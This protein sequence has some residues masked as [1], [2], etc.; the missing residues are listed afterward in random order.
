MTP[1]LRE[2]PPWIME[3]MIESQTGLVGAPMPGAEAIGAAVSSAASDGAPI[4]VTGCGTSEHG[5]MAVAE[6][7]SEALRTAGSPARAE[8]RQAL[9]AALDARAGGVCIGVSHEGT[10]RATLLALEAARGA[11][12]TTASIGAHAGSPLA[13]GADC[14]LTTPLVDGSWCHTV[15]YT[16]AILA[17]SAI[18]RAITGE[19]GSGESAIAD[20]LELRP[21]LDAL[22]GRVHAAG[23]IL[24]VGLGADLITARELALKIEEGARIPATALHLES[25]LHGHLA[26][27][28]AGATA[29]VLLAADSRPGERRDWRLR[30]AAGAAEAIGIRAIAIGTAGA[31]SG[32]PEA[33]ATLALPPAAQGAELP[34]ALLAGAVSLQLLTLSLAQLAGVSPDLIR[35]EQ[36]P[37]R[38]AAAVAGN[39]TDW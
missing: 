18:A 30:C 14:A 38:E 19:A 34:H 25:L 21:R 13:A 37:Y 15:A 7:I 23:R 33:V 32:L 31:L 24:A 36:D 28:D 16:S 8:A 22:A 39:R 11:G 4:V 5:A 20:T 3:E 9:D 12:A 6:L 17:G 1:E 2:G 27:C 26:G 29:L 35:R 10:T